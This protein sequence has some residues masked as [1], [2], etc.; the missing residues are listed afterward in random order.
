MN[1]PEISHDDLKRVKLDGQVVLLDCNGTET[2]REHHIPGAIDFEAEQKHLNEVL[3]PD[4]FSPI[5]IYC[6]SEMC[7]AW[8]TCAEALEKAGFTNLLHYAPGIKGWMARGEKTESAE[9]RH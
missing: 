2:Y 3:P 9:V 4:S 7:H 6:G 8:E 1:V 5:V